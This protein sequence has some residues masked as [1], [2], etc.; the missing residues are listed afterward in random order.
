MTIVLRLLWV[1]LAIVWAGGWWA[2]ARRRRL[3]SEKDLARAERWRNATRELSPAEDPLLVS[4]D[5][6]LT[7]G[8]DAPT[9]RTRGRDAAGPQAPTTTEGQEGV[10]S[11]P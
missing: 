6:A 7:E 10:E 11:Q 5:L 9:P 2:V 1:V 4:A 3:I 8:C